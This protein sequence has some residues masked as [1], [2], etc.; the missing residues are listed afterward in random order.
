MQRARTSKARSRGGNHPS[1]KLASQMSS[2]VW[3][4]IYSFL[5]MSKDL[6]HCRQVCK[7]WH[8]NFQKYVQILRIQKKNSLEA[9]QQS[10]L[11]LKDEMQGERKENIES[12]LGMKATYEELIELIPKKYSLFHRISDLGKLNTPPVLLSYGI[13]SVLYLLTEKEELKKLGGGLN[14]KYCKKRLLDKN[15]IKIMREMTPERITP[16]MITRFRD[17][18]NASLITPEQLA[19]ESTQA[20]YMMEWALKIVEYKDFVKNLDPET[21][22]ALKTFNQEGD[23][24]KDIAKLDS[25]LAIT[26]N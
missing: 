14:W 4:L 22:A 10:C 19:H 6:A 3:C 20:T 1:S 7:K 25:I 5:G 15:F 17:L 24:K 12:A 26:T 18:V 8:K 9:F 16:A 23:M 21:K 11:A 2:G 13:M